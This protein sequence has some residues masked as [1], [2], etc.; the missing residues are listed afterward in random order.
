[1]QQATFVIAPLKNILIDM[2]N[3]QR[4][5]DDVAGPTPIN[6]YRTLSPA[7]MAE[8]VGLL[9]SCGNILELT[10][11][12]IQKTIGALDRTKSGA[13]LLESICTQVN[14][15]K[16]I[17]EGVVRADSGLQ[18]DVVYAAV[19]LVKSKASNLQEA[20]EDMSKHI[21]DG[22]FKSFLNEFIRG[23]DRIEKF[24][25]MQSELI[26]AQTTLVTSL[27]V[28]KDQVG[29][30]DINMNVMEQIIFCFKDAPS[31]NF[32]GLLIE[33]IRKQGTPIGD[34]SFCRVKTEDLNALM[35][36]LSLPEGQSVR[37]INRLEMDGHA[38]AMG[39]VGRKGERR[40][41]I[42]RMEVNDSKLKGH[43]TL[44]AGSVDNA[45]YEQMQELRA[46]LAQ[47]AEML[48]GSLAII[49]D[50]KQG[51]KIAID[52]IA[53]RFNLGPDLLAVKASCQ[54]PVASEY[55]ATISATAPQSNYIAVLGRSPGP[56]PERR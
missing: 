25:K 29:N 8:I 46:K 54:L 18:N 13:K 33:L 32:T 52:Y 34:G 6:D 23:D 14:I 11:K 53:G 17:L 12:I 49:K 47:D 2:F 31:Q 56:Q 20:S 50:S 22:K 39:D 51:E 16:K 5:E 26:L 21:S 9:V 28:F 44:I 30:S 15:T 36:C 55:G 45:T 43:S 3:M 35:W 38:F 40:P 42:D 4:T 24:D 27:V 19:E 7:Q 1:M 48:Q 10:I 37:V 41:H